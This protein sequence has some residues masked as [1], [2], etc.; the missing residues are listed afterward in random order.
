MAAACHCVSSLYQT[1]LL[2]EFDVRLAKPQ[3]VFHGAVAA[4]VYRLVLLHYPHAYAQL[5]VPAVVARTQLPHNAVVAIELAGESFA[6]RP[7]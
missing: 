3:T 1:A 6:W 4:L 7:S 5:H 2:E